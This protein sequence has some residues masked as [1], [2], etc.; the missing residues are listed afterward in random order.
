M[1]GAKETI[2]LGTKDT[3]TFLSKESRKTAAGDNTGAEE[4][5]IIKNTCTKTFT[6]KWDLNRGI[7]IYCRFPKAM[8]ISP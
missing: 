6:V 8:K 7:I 1:F 3:A 2:L 5:K 4:I